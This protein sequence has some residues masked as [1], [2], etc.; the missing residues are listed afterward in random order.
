MVTA[1]R[2]H[3]EERRS[4][5]AR[6]ARSRVI[7][8]ASLLLSALMLAAAPLAMPPGYSWVAM[9]TSESAAQGTQGAWV[10]RLGF[11]LFGFAVIVLVN[12]ARARWG[13]W[14]LALH[15]LFGVMMVATAAFSHRPWDPAVEF[16]R[17][18][19]ILHSVAATVVGFSFALGVLATLIRRWRE[20]R[21]MQAFDVV[22]ISAAIILPLAMMQVAEYIGVFQRSMFGIAYLWYGTEAIRQRDV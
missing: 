13:R 16:N 22:S 15:L 11:V 6:N 5:R 9:T 12:M 1:D 2:L 20:D 3:S 19:D 7:V 17:L 8:L 18:E 10:A 4:P 14:A 21:W